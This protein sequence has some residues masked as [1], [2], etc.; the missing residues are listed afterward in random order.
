MSYVHWKIV[1]ILLNRNVP[2][3]GILHDVLLS[4]KRMCKGN[5]LDIQIQICLVAAVS[6]VEMLK[7]YFAQLCCYAYLVPSILF[8]FARII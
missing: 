1:A 7:Y 2:S 3:V 6:L 8:P 4:A 5:V